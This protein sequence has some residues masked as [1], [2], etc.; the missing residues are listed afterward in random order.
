MSPL[1]TH[2]RGVSSLSSA[3]TDWL[4]LLIGD[5]Q[6]VS[7]LSFADLVLLVPHEEDWL[8]VAHVRPNTGQMVFYDDIVTTVLQSERNPK[9]GEAYRTGRII[10]M[11]GPIVRGGIDVVEEAIPVV[12]DGIPIA[13]MT[14]HTPV[15]IRRDPS[16][17]ED[18]YRSLADD[19]VTMIA[20]GDFPSASAPT[21][22][23]RG[24]P[25][26]GDG[27]V[28]L[29]E[30]G[31][32]RYASP[33]A[34]SALHRLGHHEAVLDR[35]LARIV[36]DLVQ[37]SESPV[38]ETLALV[39]TGRAPWR[40]EV[41]SRGA[42][43]T[44]RA[45][46]LIRSRQRFGAL[47]LL[48][49]VSELR[50]REQELLT[51]DATIRE[52]HHRVKNNLQTVAAVLRLQARRLRE[53][54]GRAALDEAVRRVGTIALV[55]E[56]LSEAIADDVNFDDIAVKGLRAVVEVATGE[57]RI[58]SAVSGSFGLMRAEDATTLAMVISELVQ[59]AAE[60]GLG[61]REGWITIHADRYTVAAEDVLEVRITDTGRGLPEGF[62][63][64]SGLGSQIVQ[65]LIADLRGTIT[66]ANAAP[67]GAT[68]HFMARLRPL[69]RKT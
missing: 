61:D 28:R 37:H 66:W 10:G 31:L 1:N 53:P 3:Q 15:T 8:V 60:H 55:H 49:D 45:I 48:R 46:P 54:E 19:L 33:N 42:T 29:D 68:V 44:M 50:R 27:V 4:H 59:N 24:A 5:W 16:R 35:N 6:L 34:I 17:M 11:G 63:P 40:S 12:R 20:A 18:T 47:L 57:H 25:R 39:V 14:R 65:S 38:D 52:I 64:G 23:R 2:L 62:R 51:K 58:D 41:T 22:L 13:V 32:V 30:G 26:V 56:T 21:G 43:V 67:H 7:D 69:S 9:V 36:T